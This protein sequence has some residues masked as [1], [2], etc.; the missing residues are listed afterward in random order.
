[1]V[2]CSHMLSGWSA[3]G[4]IDYRGHSQLP[5]QPPDEQATTDAL[6]A[7]GP[8]RCYRFGVRSTTGRS[9]L[10]SAFRFHNKK[11]ADFRQKQ[12]Q[13]HENAINIGRTPAAA[14][15]L[16]R[17]GPAPALRPATDA[18]AD[19]RMSCTHSRP[20]PRIEEDAS[21]KVRIMLGNP[22]QPE[23]NKRTRRGPLGFVSTRF[24]PFLILS[25]RHVE[26]RK[27]RG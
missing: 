2:R 19:G 22:A 23:S 3:G 26:V 14:A 18:P 7:T 1:M 15:L 27:M 20:A 12:N 11:L 24:Q 8:T 17:A 21:L 10:V 5:G 16:W 25:L 13:Y 6:V 4:N 9:D